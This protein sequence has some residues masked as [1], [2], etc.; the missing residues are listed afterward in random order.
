MQKQHGLNLNQNS[1]AELLQP[2]LFFDQV[3]ASDK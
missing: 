2:Q 3:D 1:E